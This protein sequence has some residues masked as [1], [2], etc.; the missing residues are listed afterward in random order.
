MHNHEKWLLK[1]CTWSTS[2]FNL[3]PTQN[4][5]IFWPQNL[6]FPIDLM[7]RWNNPSSDLWQDASSPLSFRP[8]L[9]WMYSMTAIYFQLPLTYWDNLSITKLKL[10]LSL[11]FPCNRSLTQHRCELRERCKRNSITWHV[12][13]TT[14]CTTWLY[15]QLSSVQF[16]RS[17][18]SNSSRPHELQH[19]RPLCSSTTPGIHSD[20][21]PSSPWCQ[22]AISSLVTPSPPA[23]NPSQYQSLFQWVS[24][25]HKVAK[26]LEFQL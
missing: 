8:T 6:S 1:F 14:S 13:L 5:N 26:V 15:T 25:S 11:P 16:S 21:C 20:S 10:F 19:A 4:V 17:I 7:T 22:P 23:P 2:R 9:G 12:G 3:I 18:M 24:S